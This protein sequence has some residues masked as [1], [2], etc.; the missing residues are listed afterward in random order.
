MDGWTASDYAL[1]VSG[2]V[3]VI[4]A[5]LKLFQF[6]GA[7]IDA[8]R[9]RIENKTKLEISNALE[10]K[11]LETEAGERER[12]SVTDI[13]YSI[14]EEKNREIDELK[15]DNLSRPLVKQLYAK[16]RQTREELDKGNIP[17]VRSLINEM[18]ALLP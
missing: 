12:K 3:G 8:R 16:L 7:R 6:I 4:Y 11:K 5:F 9:K 14:L 2:S 17:K 15:R 1:V 13:L 10:F 18:E